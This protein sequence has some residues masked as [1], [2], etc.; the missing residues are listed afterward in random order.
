[1]STRNEELAALLHQMAVMLE[2]LEDNDYRARA[3]ARAAGV[4]EKLQEDVCAVAARGELET[5]PGIGKTLA[6]NITTWCKQGTFQDF[7]KVKIRFPEG[8]LDLIKIP[9]LGPK[10]IKVL[11]RALGI[12]SLG[13][14]EYAC[15][16]N[17]LIDIKGFGLKTQEKILKGIDHL[18]QFARFR[19]SSEAYA[20]AEGFQRILRAE[21]P[22]EVEIYLVGGLRRFQEIASD[23]D[24]LV[25]CEDINFLKRLEDRKIISNLKE[26]SRNHIMLSFDGFHVDLFRSRV[27]NNAAP[28]LFYTGSK[29]HV[30]KLIARAEKLGLKITNEGFLKEESF[31]ETPTEESCYDLLGLPYIPPELRESGE[32]VEFAEKGQLPQL[33]TE[34]D[35]RGLFHIHTVASDGV[36]DL[37]RV[38]HEAIARGYEYIGIADHSQSA[39]YARGLTPDRLQAQYKEIVEMRRKYPQVDIYW[40]IESDIL[41]DGSL[42]FPPE[43]LERFD[44][45]IGSVHSHFNMSK[46]EMT[47]RL[48]KALENPYLTI[49]GHPTGRLLLGRPPYE[50]S[51]E[52]LLE[53]AAE[54]GKIIELNAHPHRLDLDWRWCRKA[55]EMKIPVSINP[56][57]HK[58]HDFDISYG[59]MTARK[60]WLE[61]RNVWNSLNREEM[62]LVM[63]RKPWRGA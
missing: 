2:I 21:L 25:I 10:K 46:A 44:F 61:P 24:F 59:V 18:K 51:M 42:D 63:S 7:E 23:M 9:G 56:D 17:R 31:L 14:L 8:L 5:L 49:L 40:G 6:R 60:G 52:K 3:Y 4:V 45:V 37:E 13:E 15:L 29:T 11:Y 34:K 28:I 32:E 62:R 55:R 33:I 36:M 22:S 16:E 26:I 19:L 54:R 12:T 47:D 39:Y 1:M 48:I 53:K 35:I 43:I 41:P 50:L 20:L 27:K 30:E 57:A 58:P 38:I